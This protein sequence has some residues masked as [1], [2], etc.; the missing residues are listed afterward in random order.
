MKRRAT[1]TIFSTLILILVSVVTVRSQ[2]NK[3]YFYWVGRNSM[4]DSD[5]KGAIEV[6]NSLLNVDENAYEGYFLRGIAKY[7][8]GDL[9]GADNDFSIAVEK[10]PVFT[11]AYINRAITRS[12]LGN[13]DDALKDFEEAINLRPDLP[14]PYFS[15]G[16]TRLLNQQFEAAISDFD[17]FIKYEKRV[18]DAYI[19]RGICYLQLK[20]TLQAKENF[21]T[22]IKTNRENP[23]AY[24][25]RGS[26][27][28]TQGKTA[29][30]EAD[31]DMAIANDSTY[32]L[33]FFNRALIYNDTKRPMLALSDLDR[34]MELDSTNALCYFNRAIMRTQIGD[35]NRAVDDYDKAAEF[36]PDNVLVY[37]YRANL[38]TQLGDIRSAEADYTKAIE[39]YPD[40]ANAY[41]YRSNIRFMLNQPKSAKRDKTIGESKIAEHQSKLKDSTYSIYSDSTY[42]FD[43]LLSFDSQFS[44][45]QFSKDVA[46]AG[47]KNKLQLIPLYRFTLTKP[48][49]TATSTTTDFYSKRMEDFIASLDNQYITINEGTNT[50][51][52]DKILELDAEYAE[53]NRM[54]PDNW[55]LLFERAI[56]QG[57]IKQYTNSVNTYTAAIELNPI[58][59]FLYLN[60]STTEAEMIDF[61]SSI[62]NSYQRISIDSDPANRLTNS[63][64][65]RTYNYD[66][67]IADLNKAIKLY[68]DFAYAFYNRANLY[69]LS[70]ELPKAY[71]DYTKAIE[72][73][74]AFAAAY[75]NRGVI[76]I[77]MKDTRKG[78]IDISKSAELGIT[79]AYKILKEYS[80]NAK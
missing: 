70:G 53:Q 72:L 41:L 19:N 54:S 35:Y 6:L 64:Q 40:F 57:L 7:N 2:Y 8:L 27:Y 39:L 15:R 1:I 36:A 14:N 21:D 56:S 47:S 11:N 73:Y 31:F 69:A 75:Y 74:P 71:D 28:L 80:E 18:A 65:S 16:V 60:R 77:Y 76:Q 29:E 66:E 79:E 63:N 23:A 22:A 17:E 26:L 59:P 30:A 61:I 10:N 5:Y 45:S 48:D 43:K 62:D 12:R 52:T 46:Q 24:N 13:Y 55:A 50:L 25:R 51:A 34:V 58:N 67:A 78:Y 33:S 32:L 38:L 3:N 4:I 44:E 42:R 9:L 68:P 49:S 20:D 37:F